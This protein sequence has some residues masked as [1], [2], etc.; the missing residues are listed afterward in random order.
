MLIKYKIDGV[1]ATNTSISRTEVKGS[2]Y[3]NEKGGLSGRPL[4]NKSLATIKI[5]NKELQGKIPIIGV[6]GI[7]SGQDAKEK[8]DNGSQLVQIYSGLIFRGHRL[9][10]EVCS[11]IK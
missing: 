9:I 7:L 5:L 4:K 6:G 2:V 1:I 11:A 10:H 8:I 3:F